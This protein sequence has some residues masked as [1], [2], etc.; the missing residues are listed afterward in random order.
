MIFTT[1]QKPHLLF[2]CTC[3][4]GTVMF[5]YYVFLYVFCFGALEAMKGNYKNVSPTSCLDL[6]KRTKTNKEAQ[7]EVSCVVVDM[8]LQM[9]VCFSF[10][11]FFCSPG[12]DT[13]C[14]NFE[15]LLTLKNKESA[16]KTLDFWLYRKQ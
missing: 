10:A 2:V 12:T 11:Y 9:Y 3:G 14:F 15:L 5:T 6:Y 8:S 16:C 4:C 7:A 13:H 1:L